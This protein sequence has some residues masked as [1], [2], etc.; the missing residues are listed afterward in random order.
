MRVTIIGSG[1]VQHS[2]KLYLPGQELKCDD[3]DGNYLIESGVASLIV[4]SGSV[5]AD[6]DPPENKT[7][8][9]KKGK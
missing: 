4:E 6:D 1:G 7:G 5:A 3:V 2:G 9:S 8:G